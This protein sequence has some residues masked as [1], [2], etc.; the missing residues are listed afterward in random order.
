MIKCHALIRRK[1]KG[2]VWFHCLRYS[3]CQDVSVSWETVSRIMEKRIGIV[4]F[5]MPFFATIFY[6]GRGLWIHITRVFKHP[7]GG[8]FRLR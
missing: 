2:P 1:P 6:Q 4:K 5:S 3:S 8:F 7:K